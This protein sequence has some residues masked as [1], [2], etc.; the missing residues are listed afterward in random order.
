M[1]K[2]FESIKARNVNS[3]Q[4]YMDDALKKGHKRLAKLYEKR[5][6]EAEERWD[7][8]LHKYKTRQLDRWERKW[9]KA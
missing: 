8:E 6:D 9:K 2:R 4:K 5:R 1:Y 7:K 3:N